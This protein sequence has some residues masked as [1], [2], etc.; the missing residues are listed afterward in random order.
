MPRQL[1]LSVAS[2][3]VSRLRNISSVSRHSHD[4]N[5]AAM[6][7]GS[8]RLST[9]VIASN[10]KSEVNNEIK[11][12]TVYSFDDMRLYGFIRLDGHDSKG[13]KW[14]ENFI[15]V[16]CTDIKKI[17]IEGEIIAPTL[18][19]KMR[20]QFKTVP[21]LSGNTSLR[22]REVTMV[23]GELVQPFAPNYL[24]KYIKVQKARFGDAVFDIMDSVVDQL[25]MEKKIVEAFERTNFRIQRQKAKV[26]KVQELYSKKDV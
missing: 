9:Q 10:D 15:F 7:T 13:K 16:H 8:R 25:D 3:S 23:G 17:P 20:V 12:G 22:A 5:F 19:P 2:S 4:S 14:E 18:R 1:M 6:L 24:D 21:A 11:T 26:A